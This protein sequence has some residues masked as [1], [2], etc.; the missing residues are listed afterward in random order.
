AAEAGP[1]ILDGT[2]ADD[3]GYVS[4]GVNQ[5]G[6]FY[7][8]RAIENLAPGVTN[9]NTIVASLGAS[10]TALTAANSAF[11]LSTLAGNGWTFESHT[12]A[13]AIGAFF[14]AGGGAETAGII[15]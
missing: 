13:A 4:A 6:W 5:D 7:M 11:S 3:H 15:M 12:T 1:F 9:G 14:A 8:Q 2:D 10:S